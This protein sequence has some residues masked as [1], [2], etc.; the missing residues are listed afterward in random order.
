MLVIPTKTK[1]ILY[2]RH[3][4]FIKEASSRR[5]LQKT[6]TGQNAKNEQLIMECQTESDTY[7]TQSHTP[8]GQ[9]R[10]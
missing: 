2:T 8:V 9:E 5:P 3:P 7:T 1:K 10:S 4:S 6:T